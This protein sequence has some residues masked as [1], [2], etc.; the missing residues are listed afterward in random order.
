MEL[1][2]DPVWVDRYER[3]RDRIERHT[4][5]VAVFY[6][7]STATPDLAGCPELDVIA[8]Y[9]DA[10]ARTTAAETP[11][12]LGER[13]C[14]TDGNGISVVYRRD[15]PEGVFLRLHE[16]GD[17][18]MPAQLAFRDYLREH[19]DARRESERVER[20][21]AAEHDAFRSYEAARESTVR[22]LAE[23]AR[24][25]DYVDTLPGSIRE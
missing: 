14:R 3:E 24:E 1:E 21:A 10:A 8:V 18:A 16:L 25:T 11:V 17:E 4:D 12:D 9:E 15:P 22:E 5:P 6:A 2:P 19:A 20:E 13:W 23:P 7:G